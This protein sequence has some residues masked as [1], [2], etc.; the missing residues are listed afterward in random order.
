MF[1]RLTSLD[2]KLQ[3]VEHNETPRKFICWYAR[4]KV[5][6]DRNCIFGLADDLYFFYSLSFLC[7][8]LLLFFFCL[9]SL[10]YLFIYL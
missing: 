8:V 3:A 6:N 7:C 5:H 2:D 9:L 10:F 1:I 4:W